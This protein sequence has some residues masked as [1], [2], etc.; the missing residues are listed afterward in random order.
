MSLERRLTR[1]EERLGEVPCPSCHG[2]R[3]P[4]VLRFADRGEPIEPRYCPQCGRPL[5]LVIVI[6]VVDTRCRGCGEI[7]ASGGTEP[8]PRCGMLPNTG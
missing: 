4:L 7:Y 3:G 5:E 2:V 6:D 8:C 1:L